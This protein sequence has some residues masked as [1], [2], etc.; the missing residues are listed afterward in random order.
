MAKK[1]NL[2]KVAATVKQLSDETSPLSKLTV[3]E[4]TEIIEHYHRVIRT[5]LLSG[6]QISIH[7]YGLHRLKYRKQRQYNTPVTGT[8]TVPHHFIAD[9]DYAKSYQNNLTVLTEADYA[10]WLTKNQEPDNQKSRLKYLNRLEN[11]QLKL[12]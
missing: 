3:A 9:F 4:V 1:V 6:Y 12:L 2:K 10:K 7:G 5:L 8:G 11:Q